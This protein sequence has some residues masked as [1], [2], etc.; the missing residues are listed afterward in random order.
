[1]LVECNLL[2]GF[3][4]LG[5]WWLPE[6][7]LGA[8]TAAGELQLTPRLLS[9]DTAREFDAIDRNVIQT[10]LFTDAVSQTQVILNAI[11]KT[12]AAERSLAPASVLPSVGVVLQLFDRLPTAV[13][14]ELQDLLSAR[15]SGGTTSFQY[16]SDGNLVYWPIDIQQN[17]GRYLRS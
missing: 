17:V 7:E 16:F 8:T 2:I 14:T 4:E 1:V 3:N 10:V 11:N 9:I 12:P 5:D 13:V 15:L 6:L